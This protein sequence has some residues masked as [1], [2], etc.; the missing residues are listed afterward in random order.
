M[1]TQQFYDPLKTSVDQLEDATTRIENAVNEMKN[2]D[3]AD[4]STKIDGIRWWDKYN[5]IAIATTHNQ[6]PGWV[7]GW[8]QVVNTT[9]KGFIKQ[10]TC[11]TGVTVDSHYIRIVIDGVTQ[12]EGKFT[13]SQQGISVNET[14][15]TGGSFTVILPKITTIENGMAGLML[16]WFFETSFQVH[17]KSVVGSGSGQGTVNYQVYGGLQK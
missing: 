3:V 4:L 16:P 15:Y 9:G 2:T 6:A 13:S 11:N 17:F 12:Y 7:G 10:I 1:G 14:G 5:K 8:Q